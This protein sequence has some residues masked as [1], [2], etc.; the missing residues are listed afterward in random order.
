MLS[1]PQLDP[2][3]KTISAK[4][5]TTEQEAQLFRRMRQ[6]C[7]R[8][9]V[10]DAITKSPLRTLL[11]AVLTVILWLGVYLT[12]HE[13]FALLDL[14]LASEAIQA[15]FVQAGFNVFFFSLLFMITLSASI[16]FY[17]TVFRNPETAFLLTTPASAGRIVI[18]KYY[19]T[20]FVTC[21]GFILL[22][23]PML[24][25]YGHTVDAPWYYFAMVLP[26]AI[27]FVCLPT[28]VGT[29]LCLLLTLA[30]PKIRSHLIVA[31][32]G[33]TIATLGY[34]GYT[35]WNWSVPEAIT[36]FWVQQVLSRLKFAEY[37]I[38][39]SWWLS[40]GLLELAHPAQMAEANVSAWRQGLGFFSVLFS[41]ALFA[42]YVVQGI[43][44]L[45]LRPSFLHLSALEPLHLPFTLNLL[46]RIAQ[47][48]IWPLPRHMRI[49]ILKDLRL[50][51]RDP[52][53]WSQFL[54]FSGLLAMYFFAIP[55]F[56][57]G[58]SFHTWT[59]MVGYLNLAAIGLILST[60]T[61]RFI[62]PMI[63]M[64]GRR[65]W[66]LGTLPV[67]RDT[68]LWSKFLFATLISFPPSAILVLM[69]DIILGVFGHFPMIAGM[70]QLTCAVLCVGLS[71]LSVGIGARLPNLRD[72]SPAR[73]TAGFGGTLTLILS[74]IFILLTV[75]ATALPGYYF[76]QAR[77]PTSVHNNWAEYLGHPFAFV[78]GVTA[79]LAVG[80]LATWVPLRAGLRAFRRLEF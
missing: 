16:V 45:T 2:L 5:I 20:L 30:M 29:I 28:S 36:P 34:A 50:F 32:I 47:V 49:L 80:C 54:V 59:A 17:A 38:L 68:I 3:A 27:C 7:V 12:F 79:T 44:S 21:W 11:L 39:P 33:G 66:I 62:F 26:F 77:E 57:Y 61:T 64:E 31:L 55:R 58:D 14:A 22:G 15:Q 72:S 75:A 8:T 1:Q 65:F 73:I 46:D 52:L 4:T 18:Y 37:Q 69:S 60:F 25:A 74:A 40:M 35:V 67:H 76:L 53:H 71:A 10:V 48:L 56:E 24:L 63:S 19:E 9:I 41:N 6:R 13:A 51:R 43:G 78:V 23:S 42:P 70:H